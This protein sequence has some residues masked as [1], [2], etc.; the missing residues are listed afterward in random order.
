MCHSLCSCRALIYFSH[1]AVLGGRAALCFHACP[2]FSLLQHLSVHDASTDS[3]TVRL[4]CVG[5][6]HQQMR[7]ASLQARLQ[8]ECTCAPDRMQE[9]KIL[10]GV[11][12]QTLML[13]KGEQIV[14]TNFHNAAGDRLGPGSHRLLQSEGTLSSHTSLQLVLTCLYTLTQA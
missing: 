5:V 4:A 13:L 11:S 7:A 1:Q 10:N 2:G 3:K 14:H 9:S 8:A 6:Q 12:W